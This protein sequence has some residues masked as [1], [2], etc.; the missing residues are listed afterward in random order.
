MPDRSIGEHEFNSIFRELSTPDDVRR[1]SDAENFLLYAKRSLDTFML[2]NFCGYFGLWKFGVTSVNYPA[3]HRLALDANNPSKFTRWPI[4]LFVAKHILFDEEAKISDCFEKYHL[5]QKCALLW[6]LILEEPS[7]TLKRIIDSD[8][9]TMYKSEVDPML[10]AEVYLERFYADVFYGNL[11]HAKLNLDTAT[12]LLGLGICLVGKLGKRT[13]YQEESK[14]Q[15][16][17]EV[18]GDGDVIDQYETGADLPQQVALVDDVLLDKMSVTDEDVGA[19]KPLPSIYLACILAKS[20]LERS[21]EPDVEQMREKC[22]TYLNQVISHPTNWALQMSALMERCYLESHSKRRVER[23]CSQLEAIVKAVRGDSEANPFDSNRF[24]LLLASGLKPFWHAEN[25]YATVLFSLGCIPE[26]LSIFE[27]LE[28]WDSVVA[29]FR[30]MK[31]LEKAESLVRDLIAKNENDPKYHCVLG[32]ITQSAECYEKAIEVSRG[33]YPRA[34]RALGAH[35]LQQKDYDT[36]IGYFKKFLELQPISPSVWFNYGCCALKLSQLSEAAK[37]FRECVRYMPEHFEAWNNLAAVYEATEDYDRAKRAMQE[38][39][40][41]NFGHVKLWANY[42]LLCL[43]TCDYSAAISSFHRLLD[44][45]KA[46]SD[47]EVIVI[48]AKAL[49]SL[50]KDDVS[51][52]K[53]VIADMCQL[54][55]RLTSQRSCSSKVWTCYSQLKKPVDDSSIENHETY[56]HLLERAFYCD[57]NKLDWFKS[58]NGCVTVLQNANEL[59]K[60]RTALAELKGMDEDAVRT[61][62]RLMFSPVVKTVEKI[63]GKDA[64]DAKNDTIKE[65]VHQLREHISVPSTCNSES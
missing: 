53:Q 52:T 41:I 10:M 3:L 40:K 27:K 37:G 54:L 55:G 38:A 5:R 43:R 4:L 56:V 18:R 12:E 19:D 13:R 24:K 58:E 26:A 21:T 42:L 57:F 47:E 39:V 17:L 64:V 48:I 60:A 6:Q 34:Y 33:S 20:I 62:K 61:E 23:S 50:S 46:Y 51:G 44:I 25:L 14:P 7:A 1:I 22:M 8:V 59:I 32:D 63:Y 2:G 35:F 36:A 9:I 28:D 45:N 31:Q 65:L 11:S 30:S 49:L 29:C 16:C 15:L